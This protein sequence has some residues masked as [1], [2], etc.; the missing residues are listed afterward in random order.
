MTVSKEAIARILTAFLA[1]YQSDPDIFDPKDV[2][3]VQSNDWWIER[4]NGTEDKNEEQVKRGLI[5][6]MIW[7]KNFGVNELKEHDFKS[8]V[9]KGKYLNIK[10]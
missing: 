2:A 8:L 1:F 10:Y 6:A 4:F 5:N 3:M 7:R 9:E